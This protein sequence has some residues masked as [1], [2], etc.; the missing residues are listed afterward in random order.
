MKQSGFTLIELVVVIAIVGIL[1][2]IAIPS[3]AEQ[4]KKSRRSEAVTVLGD[5]QLRQERWRSNHTTYGTLA[6]VT[7]TTAA[8]F[9]GAQSNYDFAVTVNS[10]SAYTLTATPKGSQTGDRCGT[11]TLALDVSARPGVPPQKTAGGGGN[12]L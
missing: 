6:E 3:F 2:A 7:G 9:N 11:Y 12:C 5:L 4:I 1:A 10:A 8:L